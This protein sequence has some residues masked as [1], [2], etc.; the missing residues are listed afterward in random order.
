MVKCD[1]CD[2]VFVNPQPSAALLNEI[3]SEEYFKSK[4]AK[5][6]GYSDYLG[7]EASY[8]LEAGQRNLELIEMHYGKKKGGLLLDIGCAGGFF[9]K[10]ARDKG[11]FVKGVEVSDY[12][13]QFAREQ[14]G[15]NVTTGFLKGAN[16][17]D[18]EFDV[19]T[20]FDVIEHVPDPVEEMREINRVMKTDGLLVMD[21]PNIESDAARKQKENFWLIKEDHIIYFS[22][23]TIKRLLEDSGFIV[24]EISK[25]LVSKWDPAIKLFPN[26]TE[27]SHLTVVAR[28]S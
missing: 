5:K 25:R 10:V 6:L 11:W 16:Y 26:T 9:L 15:L 3:Y 24:A 14:L 7:E 1:L 12:A 22:P 18:G 28:K 13:A 8:R 27:G 23:G 19:I 2:L 21:T 4:N 20:M 17:Q